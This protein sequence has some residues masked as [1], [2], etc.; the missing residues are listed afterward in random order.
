MPLSSTI[1]RS[2]LYKAER[3][4]DRMFLKPFTVQW[5]IFNI[6]CL[7]GLPFHISGVNFP[8]VAAC[9][10]SASI[11]LHHTAISSV[12]H[13]FLCSANAHTV[14]VMTPPWLAFF[15]MPVCHISSPPQTASHFPP[16]TLF[17]SVISILF[18]SQCIKTLCHMGIHRFLQS[19]M[20]LKHHML[21]RIQLPCN[22]Y[23]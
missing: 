21:S 15:S 9:W 7:F 1:L 22:Y 4:T 10:L 19:L 12:C 2:A 13:V 3:W 5:N 20:V 18:C 16:V 6:V 8:A 11:A 17:F 23:S 14:S